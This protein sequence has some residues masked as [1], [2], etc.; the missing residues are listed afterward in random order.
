MAWIIRT[1][2]AASQ[3]LRLHNECVNPSDTA[4]SSFKAVGHAIVSYAKH[5]ESR[6]GYRQSCARSRLPCEIT[7][8]F[9]LR[10]L[11]SQEHED[12]SVSHAR[13]T[14]PCLVNGRPLHEAGLLAHGVADNANLS[15]SEYSGLLILKC[16]CTSSPNP[17]GQHDIRVLDFPPQIRRK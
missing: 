1:A 7:E 12:S 5:P 4:S 3:I 10:A 13:P 2:E 17:R 9:A 14:L 8:I 6:R 11:S 15:D 16:H